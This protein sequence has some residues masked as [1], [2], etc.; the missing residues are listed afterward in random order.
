ML[1]L[2]VGD[3]CSHKV[4]PQK[5]VAVHRS[6]WGRFVSLANDKGD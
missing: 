6:L 3:L 1:W 2:S 4:E 5:P